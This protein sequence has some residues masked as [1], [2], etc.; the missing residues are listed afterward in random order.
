M[1]GYYASAGK[2]RSDD[3]KTGE[4]LAY[5]GSTAS[6]M[7][8]PD[9]VVGDDSSRPIDY[10]VLP[11][12]VMEGGEDVQIQQGAGMAVTKSDDAHEYA[13]VEFL[14]WFTQKENNLRFVADSAYLPVRKDAN[15]IQALDEVIQK[16]GLQ[17]AP[18][19]H[20]CL[21]SVLEKGDSQ[22]YYASETFPEGY[23]ARK[24]L[25]TDLREKAA[26]DRKAVQEGIAGGASHDDAVAPYVSDAAFDAWYDEFTA[27]LDSA[28]NPS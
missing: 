24:V 26:A 14:K 19:A 17:I 7:Y 20:D 10:L 6:S 27:A 21:E 28:A 15:S 22:T 9:Q 1:N 5:T 13:S 25:D 11:A 12:P 16:D 3:V 8:F 23:A 2:F 4:I 18:K